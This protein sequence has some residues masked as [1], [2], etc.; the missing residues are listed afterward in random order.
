MT[1]ARGDDRKHRWTTTLDRPSGA[2]M[3]RYKKLTDGRVWVRRHWQWEPIEPW[4]LIPGELFNPMAMLDTIEP[5]AMTRAS[6][7]RTRKVGIAEL[8]LC[9]ANGCENL[10]DW[11]Y[12]GEGGDLYLCR[13][14]G[15]EEPVEGWT[16]I[17]E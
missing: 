13:F 8:L 3:V 12:I 1:R 11:A 17:G 6:V 15:G 10:A 9:D 14:H 5:R 7:H 4:R 16:W 2:R